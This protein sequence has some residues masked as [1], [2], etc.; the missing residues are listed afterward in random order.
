VYAFTNDVLKEHDWYCPGKTPQEIARII[1]RI[2]SDGVIMTDYPK[3]DGHWSEWMQKH[4]TIPMMLRWVNTHDHA[5]LLK[6]CKGV[7]VN[8]A[9]SNNGVPSKPG[10]ST[11]SGSPFTGPTNTAG[12]CFIK[13]CA[14][15]QMGLSHDEA[16]IIL[17]AETAKSG[18]DGAD[19]LQ[20][21]LAEAIVE[22]SKP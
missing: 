20:P 22:V 7:F 9:M 10:W 11:R 19:A 17:E 4:L 15:R 12:N 6:L 14:L 1:Q 5:E 21:G 18:D 3:F 2:S 13:Y 16:I 8:K